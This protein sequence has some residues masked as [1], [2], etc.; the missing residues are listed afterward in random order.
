MRIVRLLQ[1]QQGSESTDF[2]YRPYIR[3]LGGIRDVQTNIMLAIRLEDAMAVCA[4]AADASRKAEGC[5]ETKEDAGV[6]EPKSDL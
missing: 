4:A 2:H 6:A 1:A 3:N 5:T